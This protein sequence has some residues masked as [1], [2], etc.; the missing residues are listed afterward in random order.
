MRRVPIAPFMRDA[1]HQPRRRTRVRGGRAALVLTSGVGLLVLLPQTVAAASAVTRVTIPSGAD[2][3]LFAGC[4]VGGPGRNYTNSEVEPRVAVDP[5]TAGHL[6]AAW[7]QDRWSNGG[8]APL[9]ARHPTYRGA[10]L[11]GPTPPPSHLAAAPPRQA[12][13]ARPTPQP[14]TAARPR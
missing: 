9:V 7:Q 13:S 3:N 8:A 4:T 2:P 11:T 10:S 5:H 6:V 1:I 14:A 12:P